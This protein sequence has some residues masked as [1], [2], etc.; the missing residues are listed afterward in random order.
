MPSTNRA[1]F[2]TLCPHRSVASRHCRNEVQYAWEQE[3]A[4]VSV[5]LEPTELPGGLKL[6][7]GSAQAIMKY[8]LERR[9][10]STQDFH[11]VWGLELFPLEAH[12]RSSV[13]PAVRRDGRG[14]GHR[15]R[16]T[17]I[18]CGGRSLVGGPARRF[19]SDQNPCRSETP[20][21]TS[22]RSVAV[23][24]FVNMSNDPE[25][26]FFSDGISEDILNE[27]ARGTSLTVRPRSTSFMFKASEA[28]SQSI[29]QQLNVTHVVEGSVRK[30]GDRIRVSVHLIEVASNHSVW[31]QQYE[32]RLVDIFKVQDE[33]T[34]EILG[35]LDVHLSSR[36][37]PRPF[38]NAEAYD[39][40]LRG[41]HALTTWINWTG[42][43]KL[44]DTI[45]R[46]SGWIPGTMTTRRIFSMPW[47]GAV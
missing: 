35:A 45:A 39:A 23:L 25:Q 5:Y 17:R 24:P 28:D 36:R 33:I 1:G 30:S 38:S 19:D 3:K 10:V 16:S 4:L 46:R 44:K 11:G 20:R 41:R 8:D 26:E 29:G 31:S 34:S 42:L 21:S 22:A 7:L 9:G 18:D 47:P 43:A 37:S 13:P 6:T 27:L 14:S 32:R 2:S 12:C 15:T 40:F